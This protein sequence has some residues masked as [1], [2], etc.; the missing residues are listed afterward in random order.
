MFND[1]KG[2]KEMLKDF[3]S[4]AKQF[5]R[6]ED[7][8]ILDFSEKDEKN[9][10]PDTGQI[11][12]P[13]TNTFNIFKAIG[14]QKA[15]KVIKEVIAGKTD[16]GGGS[17]DFFKQQALGYFDNC[18]LI[19]KFLDDKGANVH[20]GTFTEVTD[21]KRKTDLPDPEPPNN[22]ICWFILFT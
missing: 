11:I 20:L 16:A 21:L 15:L 3:L 9:K 7:V 22:A 1:G 13:T 12:T 5:D 4:W 6:M 2:D 14:V 18:G 19:L 10:N 8:F 17:G